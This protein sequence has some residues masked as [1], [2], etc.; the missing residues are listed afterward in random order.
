[1]LEDIRKGP[2]PKSTKSLP[3]N[4]V[5]GGR[6]NSAVG[7]VHRMRPEHDNRGRESRKERQDVAKQG[8]EGREE[9]TQQEWCGKVRIRK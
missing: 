4:H 2:R 8:E 1:M 7:G 3:C 9:T 5:P 6:L